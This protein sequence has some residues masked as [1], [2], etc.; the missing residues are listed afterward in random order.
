M[1]TVPCKSLVLV[2][3]LI[4]CLLMPVIS[5]AT[6]FPPNLV[7]DI[8]DSTPD[9]T[10]T[11]R[12]D[13]DGVPD[14][15]DAINLVLGTSYASNENVDHLFVEPDYVWQQLNGDV[16]LIGLTAGN[17][18][19][20]GVYTDL[21]VGT[22]KSTM[23]TA[24]GF[25]FAGD[26]TAANPFP[27]ANVPLG[28]GT[29]FGWYLDSAGGGTTATYYSEPGLN[30]NG[31]DH[32]MTYI[33]GI[34]GMTVYLDY[35]GGPVTHTFSNP[36]LVGW[37]DLAWNG[38]TLGDEDYDDMIYIFD[39]TAPI[40]EPSTVLLLGIGVLGLVGYGIRRRKRS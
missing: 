22:V 30:P 21:G 23:L 19:T 37:E 9:G 3:G 10:P 27:A 7:N 26:G 24:T 32:M 8:Y 29:L 36:F 17:V 34:S 31:F 4:V 15:N 20:L 11:P 33:L 35:G 2:S 5:A 13:N 39:K 28:T 14:I 40:P 25:G 12:E 1:N 16:A 6:P 18:N 38:T